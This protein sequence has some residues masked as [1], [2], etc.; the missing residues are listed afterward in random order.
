[1]RP[2]FSV[3][4]TS[5]ADDAIVADHFRQ[6]WLD[7]DIPENALVADWRSRTLA[8]L[9]DG[10]RSQGAIGFVAECAGR[11]VGSLVAQ[12]FGDLYPEVLTH[13]HRRYAYVWGVY[14]ESAM[15]HHG[16]ATTLMKSAVAA[17]R[18]GGYSRVYLH[19]TPMGRP[20]YEGIGFVASNEM[21][22]ELRT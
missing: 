19:A 12:R 10:R 18:A 13:A 2:S 22:L 1:M 20:V 8:F 16:V 3:R 15:R 21:R 6:M 7:N 14:V 5:A 11:A 9:E 4:E 17:L